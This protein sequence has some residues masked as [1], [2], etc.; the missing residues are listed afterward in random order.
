MK[1]KTLIFF[2]I[3]LFGIKVSAQDKIWSVEIGSW[4]DSVMASATYEYNLINGLYAG[5]G[6]GLTWNFAYPISYYD[7]DGHVTYPSRLLVPIYADVKY[8]IGQKKIRPFV[9]LKGGFL[10]DYTHKD[11]GF[12]VRPAF[13]LQIKKIGVNLGFEYNNLKGAPSAFDKGDTFLRGYLGIS[14]SF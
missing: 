10:S 11:V 14:Y 7:G 8:Y 3:L 4:G 12:F 6:L 2:V 13:G 9:D 1:K 5:A